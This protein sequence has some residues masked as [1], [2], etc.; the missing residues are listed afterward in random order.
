MPIL[1]SLGLDQS[2]GHHQLAGTPPED[3]PGAKTPP[4]GSTR[5]DATAGTGTPPSSKA[6][7]TQQPTPHRF[8]SPDEW[9]RVA[10]GIGA[11]TKG[12]DH[13]VVHPTS[14][15]YPPKGMPDGLYRRVVARRFKFRFMYHSTS[16]LKWTL[17]ILQI[18]LGAVLTALGSVSLKD[19][20]PIT[21][22]AANQTVIS[23]LL[24]LMHNS[25]IPERYRSNEAE[26]ENVES[27][28]R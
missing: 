6:P 28:L 15:V 26:F 14:W 4:P 23:G 12:E 8:L 11:I 22:L 21:V 2:N 1:P 5:P 24:A 10:H 18:I 20:I 25:G 9:A 3:S 7:A 13:S 16:I 17:M 19:G 27:H